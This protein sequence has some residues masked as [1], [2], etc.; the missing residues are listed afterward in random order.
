MTQSPITDV[1]TEL[2]DDPG[3]DPELVETNVQDM[4]RA[5]R[6]LGGRRALHY[7][8]HR[9]LGSTLPGTALTLL[10]IGTGAGDLPAA[11]VGW[12]D[13]RDLRI[14]PMG[15]ERVPAAARFAARR[16]LPTFVGCATAFP[17]RPKSVDIVL[18][19]QVVHHF[20]RSAAVELLQAC[21]GFARKA[22]II[23]DLQRSVVARAGFWL[24]AHALRFNSTTV[25][26]GLTSIRRGL[27]TREA[28]DL[29]AAAGVPGEVIS[30]A[31]Y[32][33][34]VVW[35]PVRRES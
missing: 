17:V 16:G 27:T 12:G 5:N 33:L 24:G 2:L 31:P 30:V 8:L 26:D 7:G 35:H 11:V 34:V 18:V 29:V 28:Q 21:D 15:L 4:A 6:W 3:A 10:D 20:R 22:V 19:S 13:A 23:V 32:R 9:A 14:T 1:G 25:E